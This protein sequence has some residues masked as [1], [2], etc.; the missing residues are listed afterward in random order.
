MRMHKITYEAIKDRARYFL[1]FFKGGESLINPSSPRYASAILSVRTL[2]DDNSVL[3]R[4]QNVSSYLIPFEGESDYDFKRRQGRSFYFNL[5]SQVINA[6]SDAVTSKVSRNF[7]ALEPFVNSNVDY[8]E[9]TWS[10]FVNQNAKFTALFGVTATY[11]DYSVPENV[12]SLGDLISVGAGPKTILINPIQFAWVIVSPYGEVEEFAWFENSSAPTANN[13]R[14]VCIRVVNK[15]G[16]YIVDSAVNVTSMESSLQSIANSGKITTQGTHPASLNGKLPVVF[17]FYDRDY[18]ASYPVGKSLVNDLVDVARAVYNYNSSIENIHQSTFP[19]LTIP[20]ARSGGVM[21]PK[22]EMAVGSQNALPYDSETGTPNYIAPPSDPARELREHISFVIR[23]AYQQLGLTLTLDA[24]AQIQSGEALKIR[25]REFESYASMFASNMLKFETK[26]LEIFK[27]YLG[28]V[29][30]E[31][32]ITYPKTF[33][34]PQTKEDLDNAKTLIDVSF[35]SNSGK[36]AALRQMLTV[37]LS[38]PEDQLNTVIEEST[39]KLDL[40]TAVPEQIVESTVP[41][42]DST[43]EIPPEAGETA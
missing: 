1:D 6:Y 9:S 5:V 14:Q 29:D 41:D 37:A 19:I 43:K 35:L 13:E 33:S 17:N 18:T 40:L 21:P 39:V 25:S 3:H 28:L 26:V 8:R 16:W 38:L 34:I 7:G 30:E 15:Q 10:E 22:T 42:Q 11:V 23:H 32:S 2:A 31:Y 24:G 27:L 12:T 20:L 36:V 4:T